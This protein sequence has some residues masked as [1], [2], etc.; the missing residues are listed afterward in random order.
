SSDTSLRAGRAKD[1]GTGVQITCRLWPWPPASPGP[2]RLV[3]ADLDCSGPPAYPT[4]TRNRPRCPGGSV[5]MLDT[6]QVTRTAEQLH[7]PEDGA[8]GISVCAPDCPT[9]GAGG[10]SGRPGWPRPQGIR[11]QTVVDNPRVNPGHGMRRAFLA[12]ALARSPVA[13]Q[14]PAN[15]VRSRPSPIAQ[16]VARNAPG[17]PGLERSAFTRRR[18]R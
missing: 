1:P 11:R 5:L 2:P 8:A 15:V 14:A 17:C 13:R 12:P 9:G 16:G 7:P 6:P 3:P 10:A 4:R 18:T